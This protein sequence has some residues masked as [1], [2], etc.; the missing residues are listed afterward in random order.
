[1]RFWLAST[2]ILLLSA[3]LI[4]AHSIA[5]PQSTLR[6]KLFVIGLSKT[7]TTSIGDALALLGYKRLGWKDIRS[8][9]LVHTWAN[10]D[11]DALIDQTRFYDAFED[12][13]WPRMFREMAELYPD[14][15]FVWLE[16]MRRHVGRGDWQPY[17]WFYG[18]TQVEGNEATVL[19]AYRN[20]TADVR[21]FF[22]DKQERY[23]EMNIDD[24]DRNWDTLCSVAECPQGRIPAVPFP[25]SNTATHWN[26][27][28][29]VDFLHWLWSWTITRIEEWSAASYYQGGRPNTNVILGA[30]WSVIDVV[31]QACSELYFKLVVQQQAPL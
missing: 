31:E 21:A 3:I 28:V 27:N 9:H 30:C 19:S 24:G 8:R 10:G 4:I 6:P 11:Y 1:M 13:P 12:L 20:H 25:K 22:A 2:P 23:A 26:H 15:K 7:G 17:A 16:S 18:A 5:Q 29:L 14:S